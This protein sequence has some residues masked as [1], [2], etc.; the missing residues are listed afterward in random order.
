M[1]DVVV[2]L[3][4]NSSVAFRLIRVSLKHDTIRCVSNDSEAPTL[5]VSAILLVWS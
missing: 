2:E 1:I 3:R 4:G 5:A